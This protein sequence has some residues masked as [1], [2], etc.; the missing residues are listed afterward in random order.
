[1][2]T[3]R[4]RRSFSCRK[5][6]VDVYLENRRLKGFNTILVN[7]VEHYFATNPPKNFY[8]DAPFLTPGDF[9]T[10]NE[11]YFAH[12]EYVISKAAEK[13]ILVMLAPAYMGTGGGV[14]GW[15]QEMAA[16]GTTKLRG[17]GQYLANRF[18]SL[19]NILW[20]HGG[21]TNPPDRS[22]MRV[23]AEGIRS[24]DGRWLHTFHGSRG[25]SALGF[26][27][28]TEPWLQV[29]TIYTNSTVVPSAFQGTTGRQCRSSSSRPY[30]RVRVQ[31]H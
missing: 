30:T 23:I 18:L 27:G 19:D 31:H 9:S 29:N 17:Y 12:A 10:P 24:V 16:N 25:T 28:T 22:L 8:G 6:D 26:L 13:G 3:H 1:M 15:Y 20:V 14:Q 21:D 2:A 11:A 5:R 7:L 4:R